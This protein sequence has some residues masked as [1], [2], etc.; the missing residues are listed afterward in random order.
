MNL[1]IVFETFNLV[2]GAGRREFSI[3][4][5]DREQRLSDLGD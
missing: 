3:D 1:D 5:S 4:E 2:R